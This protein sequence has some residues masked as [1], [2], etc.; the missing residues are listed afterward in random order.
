MIDT[1]VQQTSRHLCLQFYFSGRSVATWMCKK[2]EG[3]GLVLFFLES[4]FL[5]IPH[6]K[7]WDLGLS[8]DQYKANLIWVALQFYL[9]L[10]S[11]KMLWLW[12]LSRTWTKGKCWHMRKQNLQLA[13][14]WRLIEG[15][16]WCAD[17]SIKH[18]CHQHCPIRWLP[19]LPAEVEKG[20]S[21]HALWLQVPAGLRSGNHHCRHL[22]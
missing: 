12:L 15:V 1:E 7:H 13:L 19:V 11:V 2:W 20:S 3:H 18:I 17:T 14:Q 5:G 16:S 22:W 21:A 10:P 9:T 4:H 6:K 8:A